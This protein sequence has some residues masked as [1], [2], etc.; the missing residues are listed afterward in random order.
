MSG[1]GRPEQLLVAVGEVVLL[2][3]RLVAAQ[4]VVGEAGLSRISWKGV[5][6]EST[7]RH[8]RAGIRKE[9]VNSATERQAT[10]APVNTAGERNPPGG[11]DA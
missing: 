9:Q 7:D 6:G 4:L 11:A 3:Q 10:A 1:A 2:G 5:R 8:L